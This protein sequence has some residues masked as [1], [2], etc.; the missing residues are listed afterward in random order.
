M[1]VELVFNSAYIEGCNVT[2]PQTQTILDG[3]VVNNVAVSDIQ[4]VLNL[5]DGWKYVLGHIDDDMSIDYICKVNELVSR[6]ESLDWGVLRTGS[7][8]ISGTDFKPSVPDK[9]D[10]IQELQRIKKIND[11]MDQAL[12][13]FCYAVR[14]QLFWEGNKRTAIMIANKILIQN[15]EGL[16]TIDSR[17]A[18]E[19]NQSLL[20]YYD[21]NE[22]TP[23]LACL[24]KCIKVME[25]NTS[26]ENTRN[27]PKT[28]ELER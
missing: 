1:F 2:F 8:G 11:P 6:N 17:N 5:R 4:T 23:L 26:M 9:N 10:V 20:H 22:N 15:G 19:F 27:N 16:L 24:K 28:E 18:E 7:V 12:H 3:A 14:S 13:I 21:T 25:R